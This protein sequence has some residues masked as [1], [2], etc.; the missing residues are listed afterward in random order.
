MTLV[1]YLPFVEIFMEAC[2]SYYTNGN[3]MDSMLLPEALFVKYGT[4]FD[5]AVVAGY[6]VQNRKSS[7]QR[8]SSRTILF[9]RFGGAAFSRAQIFL[10]NFHT[11]QTLNRHYIPS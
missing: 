9:P 10:C 11:T 6:Y 7:K 5:A 2:L 8:K 3:I 1:A 4:V